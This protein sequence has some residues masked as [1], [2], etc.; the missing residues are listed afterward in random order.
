M[1]RSQNPSFL[2]RFSEALAPLMTGDF[3]IRQLALV[4]IFT[5][6]SAALSW[7]MGLAFTL[8]SVAIT[9]LI[10][11]AFVVRIFMPQEGYDYR[12]IAPIEALKTLFQWDTLLFYSAQLTRSWDDIWRSLEKAR[13]DKELFSEILEILVTVVSVGMV[14]LYPSPALWVLQVVA[15]G[16]IYQLLMYKRPFLKDVIDTVLL[17]LGAYALGTSAIL[18]S[19]WNLLPMFLAYGAVLG[20]AGIV[21]AT[22]VSTLV[23]SAVIKTALVYY[24]KKPI[25]APTGFS[26]QSL[27][28]SVSI[29][30]MG[31]GQSLNISCTRSNMSTGNIQGLYNLLQA[32]INA[33]HNDQPFE[34]KMIPTIH[35][36]ALM[37]TNTWTKT[38]GAIVSPSH[39]ALPAY[40]IRLLGGDVQFTQDTTVLGH[41][42]KEQ[43]FSEISNLLQNNTRGLTGIKALVATG[44]ASILPPAIAAYIK[45]SQ[46]GVGNSHFVPNAVSDWARQLGQALVRCAPTKDT[47]PPLLFA[48]DPSAPAVTSD[49]LAQ[50]PEHGSR[51]GLNR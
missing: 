37:G 14:V 40:T 29:T 17:G 4:I 15:F 36:A 9:P 28:N 42:T 13:K 43:F 8:S 46:S 5:V 21:A 20:A 10:G 18:W 44:I 35:F 45:D 50:L 34:L 49:R 3:W 41:M 39:L 33:A 16:C 25:Y 6:V 32:W 12:T 11:A 30:V 2:A 23:L 27:L 26:V 48:P 38:E 24:L 51:A 31:N 19:P 47:N 22:I 7:L 1:H